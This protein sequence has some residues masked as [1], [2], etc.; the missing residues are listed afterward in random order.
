[1]GARVVLRSGSV[2]PARVWELVRMLDD[3]TLIRAVGTVLDDQRKAAQARADALATELAE[4]RA[5]LEALPDSR[6]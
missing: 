5:E 1:V 4:V 3:E 6:T 2:I